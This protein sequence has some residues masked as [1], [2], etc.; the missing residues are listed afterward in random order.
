MAHDIYP[1]AT[2]W[3]RKR[4]QAENGLSRST[5]YHQVAEGLFPKPVR[6]GPRAVGWPAHEV[7]T[8]NAARISG[9]SDDEIRDLVAKLH[10][11]RN[12]SIVEPLEERP[13]SPRVD[14]GR[15]TR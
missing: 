8:L 6:L 3:R 9:K 4:V 1:P 12:A 11:E 15:T 2:I 7:M 13:R 14:E 5:I 10:E